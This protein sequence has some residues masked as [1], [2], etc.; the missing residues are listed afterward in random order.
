MIQQSNLIPPR[1]AFTDLVVKM[2]PRD[3]RGVGIGKG[4]PRLYDAAIHP[5]IVT[6]AG[7]VDAAQFNQ[8]P[9][10]GGKRCAVVAAI[11][12]VGFKVTARSRFHINDRRPRP[13]FPRCV[14][15]SVF[16]TKA[17]VVRCR[18]ARAHPKRCIARLCAIG[19][20][21]LHSVVKPRTQL[22]PI[23]EAACANG[24]RRRIDRIRAHKKID[25]II[26]NVR[27]VLLRP[28][29]IIAGGG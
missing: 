25:D 10:L 8:M 28:R 23:V 21:S 29:F 5:E 24:C 2:Q 11:R 18:R 14:V 13:V 4:N 26:V 27:C 20:S 16:Q 1:L 15:S 6:M 3:L 19:E 22:F 7:P 12:R 9:L 17:A